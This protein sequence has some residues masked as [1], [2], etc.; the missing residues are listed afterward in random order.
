MRYSNRADEQRRSMTL[1]DLDRVGMFGF[2]PPVPHVRDE[3]AGASLRDTW[4]MSTAV[5]AIE[6]PESNNFY[7]TVRGVQPEQLAE[8]FGRAGWAVGKESWHEYGVCCEWAE[9]TFTADDGVLVAGMVARGRHA[10]AVA[11]FVAVGFA[12]TADPEEPFIPATS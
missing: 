11:A 6:W 12:C 1:P 10:D 4:L 7:A 3:E 2:A 8:A 9:M 5:D